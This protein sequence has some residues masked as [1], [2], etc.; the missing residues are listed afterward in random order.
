MKRALRRV[1]LPAAATLFLAACS[2]ATEPRHAEAAVDDGS[3]MFTAVRDHCGLPANVVKDGG[4]TLVL[5]GAGSESSGLP[6][7]DMACAL[8]S[9]SVPDFIVTQMDQTRA[10]DGRQTA[11][12]DGYSYSWI[13]HPDSGLDI[14][15]TDSWPS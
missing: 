10:L 9:I 6:I 14:T 7:E 8:N 15:I 12:H 5:D 4:A 2:G 13:Y 1:V 11:T 3:T